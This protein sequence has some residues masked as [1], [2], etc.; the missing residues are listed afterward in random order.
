[1]KR[2]FDAR[3]ELRPDAIARLHADIGELLLPST[4]RAIDLDRA[5]KAVVEE[6]SFALGRDAILGRSDNVYEAAPTGIRKA[7]GPAQ[8]VE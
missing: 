1:V 4:A 7:V 3:G 6:Q 2:F 8:L 5:Y